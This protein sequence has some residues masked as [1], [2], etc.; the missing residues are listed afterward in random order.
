MQLHDLLHQVETKSRTAA[1]PVQPVERFEYPLA[2]GGRNAGA[3]VADRDRG[4]LVHPNGDPPFAAAMLDRILD[5]IAQ[6]PFQ[7]SL[8]ASHADML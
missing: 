4:R 8:I 7:R 6:R 3:V 1:P 2:V 5:Q